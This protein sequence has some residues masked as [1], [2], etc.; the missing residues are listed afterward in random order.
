MTGL[1]GPSPR[2]G[3]RQGRGNRVRRRGAGHAT[4]ARTDHH[5]GSRSGVPQVDSAADVVDQYVERALQARTAQGLPVA[6]EDRETLDRLALL[7]TVTSRA[8]EAKTPATAHPR[9][10]LRAAIGDESPRFGPKWPQRQRMNVGRPRPG[11]NQTG[12]G[13]FSTQHMA[14]YGED[15]TPAARPVR[16]GG[17][18]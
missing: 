14:G 9:A 16:P 5:C 15:A 17:A 13:S 3:E 1:C 2:L 11:A 12:A 6:I 18:S 10:G 7:M 8:P 4:R